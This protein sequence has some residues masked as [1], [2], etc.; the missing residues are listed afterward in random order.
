MGGEWINGA[1]TPRARCLRRCC[2]AHDEAYHDNDCT[3]ASWGWNVGGAAGGGAAGGWG[4]A[5]CGLMVVGW[6]SDCADANNEVMDC[7]T[8]CGLDPDHN[9]HVG[10]WYCANWG[11]YVTIGPQPNGAQPDFP[12]LA[13]ATAACS[14]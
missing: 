2:A 5:Q 11:R 14:N 1:N 3:W 9:Q 8:A 12:N 7:F 4:G 13:A 6:F 10:E